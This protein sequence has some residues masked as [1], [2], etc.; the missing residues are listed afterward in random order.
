MRIMITGGE[1]MIGTPIC[2]ILKEK[3]H[4]I[5]PVPHKECDLTRESDV[6][7]RFDKFK[8]DMVIHAAGYS[9]GVIWNNKHPELIF[10]RT[11]KMAIN[12]L[13]A[14]FTF[15]VQKT[16]SVISS[17]AYPDLGQE[18]LLE[19]QLWEGVPN[20]SVECHG[21][22]KRIL[23]AYSRQI[24]KEY[25]TNYFSAILTNSYGPKDSF[26]PLKTKV[27]AAL[28]RR[29]IEAKQENKPF[30]ECWG[31][32]SSVREFMYVK[33]AAAAIVYLLENWKWGGL[34]N[35]GTG[36]ETSI[37]ELTE[38]VAKLTGYEGEIRWDTTKSDGQ[39]RRL[40][41]S[42]KLKNLGF[43]YQFSLEEGLKEMIYWYKQNKTI[44]DERLNL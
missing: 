29:F 13:E 3:G 40:L 25:G 35:V 39:M 18:T 22:A 34:V 32:G 38:K 21:L 14:C 37:K 12:V 31:T 33:D 1:S 28:I 11:A 43:K 24:N 42:T 26:H 17:C 2:D 6:M 27:V 7:T 23:D 36:V 44:V 15:E 30:V 20:P 41:D 19:S 16:L 10:R 9:G 4:Q 5:D 8:P